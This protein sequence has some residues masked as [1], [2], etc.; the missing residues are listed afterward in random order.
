L[1]PNRG[2]WLEFETSNRDILSVKVDR[3]RKMPVTILLRAIGFSSNEEIMELFADVDTNQDHQYIRTTLEKEPTK[4]TDQAIIELYHRP[5]A[6]RSP[7]ARERAGAPGESV[8]QPAPLRSGEG[9][10]LQAEQA[11][12]ARQGDAHPHQG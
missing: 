5:A 4:N 2:A 1:I 12:R 6:R 11:A 7:D 9:G 3:K 10:A 8:L